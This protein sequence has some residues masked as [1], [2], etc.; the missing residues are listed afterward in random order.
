MIL[1]I[2]LT[3]HSF[4]V[5][6]VTKQAFPRMIISHIQPQ[7]CSHSSYHDTEKRRG[8]I[9]NINEEVWHVA[10]GSDVHS[11][12]YLPHCV[13]FTLSISTGDTGVSVVTRLWS[14]EIPLSGVCLLFPLSAF[15]IRMRLKTGK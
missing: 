3:F 2:L 9:S 10:M 14:A 12:P 4:L 8:D 11:N 6:M 1:H 7:T 15:I 5:S 13:F